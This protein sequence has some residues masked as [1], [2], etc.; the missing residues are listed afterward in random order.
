MGACNRVLCWFINLFENMGGMLWV[1]GLAG[2]GV[3][4]TQG[5][6]DTLISKNGIRIRNYI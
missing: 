2:L 5:F 4:C 3:R 1:S 6:Q